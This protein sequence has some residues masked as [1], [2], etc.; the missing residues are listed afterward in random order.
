MKQDMADR[1]MALPASDVYDA[2]S[3]GAGPDS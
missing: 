1:L 3:A 2:R